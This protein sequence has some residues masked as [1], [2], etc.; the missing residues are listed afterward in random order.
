MYFFLKVALTFQDINKAAKEPTRFQTLYK[1][2]KPDDFPSWKLNDSQR[3][4][5]EASLHRRLTLI[6]GPPGTGFQVVV[7]RLISRKNSHCYSFS[8]TYSSSFGKES[9]NL[10]YS[11]YKCCC[12]QLTSGVDISNISD[13]RDFLTLESKHF[14][15][16][17][18]SKSGSN[19]GE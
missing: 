11:R 3:E 19:F 7:S 15:L 14:E 12:G 18:Q 13:I 2:R 5:I 1:G 9:S 8:E 17:N 6:Q 4:V 10:M 16:E